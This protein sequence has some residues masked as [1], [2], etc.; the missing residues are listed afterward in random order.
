MAS[1]RL[2]SDRFFTS[3]Y[4]ADV[5]TQAGLDWIDAN[6][7]SS[8]LCRHYPGVGSAVSSVGN[9]FTPGSGQQ[10]ERPRPAQQA[11]QDGPPSSKAE[12][13]DPLRTE[14]PLFGWG[15][16]GPDRA[17]RRGPAG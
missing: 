3:D 8:V 9:A 5:Y 4:T 7:M 10:A 14:L 17:G 13:G 15:V 11:P 6:T 1:R 16:P 2:N 12:E